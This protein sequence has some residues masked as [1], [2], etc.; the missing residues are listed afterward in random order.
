MGGGVVLNPTWAKTGEMGELQRGS[1][2]G[3][4]S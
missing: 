4:P 1:A 2:Q 3:T